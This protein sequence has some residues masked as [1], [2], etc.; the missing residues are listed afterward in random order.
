MVHDEVLPV[1]LVEHLEREVSA[2]ASLW[3][4][5]HV[6]AYSSAHVPHV[7]ECLRQVFP[8]RVTLFQVGGVDVARA[9]ERC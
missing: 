5:T 4:P 1:S 9:P 8:V 3:I 6:N 2:G 7:N